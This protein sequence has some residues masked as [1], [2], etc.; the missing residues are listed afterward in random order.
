MVAREVLPSD[1][2]TC[3]LGFTYVWVLLATA[4]TSLGLVAVSEVWSTTMKR[5]QLEQLNWAGAQ[6]VGAIAS[7]YG[8]AGAIRQLPVRLDDLLED[9]RAP[10]VRRHLRTIYLNPFTDSPDWELLRN[11]S[12]GIYGVR[13]TVSGR[14]GRQVREFTYTIPSDTR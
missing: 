9:R 13:A 6:Y 1:G 14:A 4:L 7:Y 2:R 11:Q 10:I 12:G 3:Q 5:Q 8:A